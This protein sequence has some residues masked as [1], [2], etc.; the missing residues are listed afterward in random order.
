MNS[1]SRIKGIAIV[2]GSFDPI[3]Y[4]HIDIVMRA[5]E[6]YERVIL[7]IMINPNKKY[8]FTM[9][10]RK[11]IAEAALSGFERVEVIT[12]EGM[13]WQLAEKLGACAI[14]KGYRNE[15]DFAYETEMAEFNIQH[16]PNAPTVLLK[17]DGNLNDLSS[18]YVRER[19]INGESIEGL[20]PKEAISEI[21]KII[22]GQI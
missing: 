19:I 17:A 7:A 10:Q 15:T 16:N 8:M 3:T 5:A 21:N 4:G 9:E 12:S 1:E 11:H 2:P 6:R 14:V 22:P 13:L 20:L 18:T